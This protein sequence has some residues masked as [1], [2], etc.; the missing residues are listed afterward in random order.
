MRNES[1][2]HEEELGATK[3]R[4]GSGTHLEREI[5]RSEIER[6]ILD[7]AMRG[8]PT[9]EGNRIKAQDAIEGVQKYITYVESMMNEGRETATLNMREYPV[10]TL[11]SA[12][13]D[14]KWRLQ[15]EASRAEKSEG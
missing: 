12:A 4:G 10:D 2:D 8:I 6:E 5:A 7:T 9:E 11:I 14:L 1:Y 15:Q 3:E 13:E